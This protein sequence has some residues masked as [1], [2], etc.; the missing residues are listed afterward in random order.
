MELFLGTAFGFP[1]VALTVPL[2]V[3]ALYW[4]VV[5]VGPADMELL[6]STDA[7]GDPVGASAVMGRLGLGRAPMMVELTL[8]LLSG[9]LVSMLG[10]IVTSLFTTPGTALALALGTVVLAVA[11]VAAWAITSGAVLA[12]RRFL[13]KRRGSSRHELVGRTCV[14]RVGAAT[15]GSGHAEITTEA[16]AV[17]TV[18]VRTIG[19]EVLPTGST[20]LIFEYGE[21]Q[22]AFLVTRFD[23]AL[24]PGKI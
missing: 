21:K 23:E 8:L 1:T 12:V 9:W 22:D 5:A 3:I 18:P 7:D 17:L 2:L 24:D 4:I 6:D 10:N 14:I 11:L 19:G 13:P 20:A 16:G 15:A